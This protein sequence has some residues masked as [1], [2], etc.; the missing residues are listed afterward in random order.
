VRSDPLHIISTG[1]VRRNSSGNYEDGFINE[2]DLTDH[3]I[4]VLTLENGDDPTPGKHI[5]EGL[6]VSVPE[7]EQQVLGASDEDDLS[8]EE[9]TADVPAKET[10]GTDSG[11]EEVS[12]DGSDKGPPDNGNNGKGPDKDKKDDE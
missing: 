4:Y 7:D 3:D 11:E 5:V 2:E 6:F 8:G 9:T 10:E 12:E 1:K